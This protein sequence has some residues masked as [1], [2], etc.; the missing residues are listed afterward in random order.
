MC[1]KLATQEV[2]TAVEFICRM[3]TRESSC[4]PH[5]SK[6]RGSEAGLTVRLSCHAGPVTALADA[7]GNSGAR[8]TTLWCCPE[9]IT[10]TH[11]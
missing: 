5:L 1:Y 7:T 4:N 10:P 6:G 3:L 11:T 2:D 9:L 8:T